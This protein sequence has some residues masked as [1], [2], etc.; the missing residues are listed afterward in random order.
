MADIVSLN[1]R[2]P[3][4]DPDIV[5]AFREL[6]SEA[7]NGR[8]TGFIVGYFDADGNI[9]TSYH[10]ASALEAIGVL[11]LMQREAQSFLSEEGD[12]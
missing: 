7:Q 3:P 12:A 8:M 9:V 11:C 4:S 10:M 6:L 5:K 1:E 2:R